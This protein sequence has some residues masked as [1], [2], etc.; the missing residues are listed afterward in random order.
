MGRP[1]AELKL[2]NEEREELRRFARRRTIGSAMAMRSKIVLRCASG[3]DNVDVAEELGLSQSMVSKWRRRFI[4][5]GLEG[6]LDEP[7]VGR[8]RPVT[9]AD[10]ERVV[11]KT[12]HDS[13]RK[14]TH[15]STRSLAKELGMTQSAV[16]RIWK[17]FGLRPD[18]SE[19]FSLSKDPQFVEK[20]RDI[21]GLYMAPPENA[22]VLCVDEKSQMQALDRTQP[23]LP[24][25]PAHPER[26]T[27][28]YTRYGT[29]SLFAA[30]DIATG[31]VIGKT[32][33]RHR[34]AE[35]RKFLDDI[36]QAVPEDLDVHLVMDSYGTHKTEMIKRWLLRHP[37]YHVHFTPT[38]SSWLNL[39]ESFFSIVERSVTRRG[40]HKS[41]RALEKDLRAFLDAHNKEPVPYKWTKT[42]DQILAS[43]SRHCERAGLVREERTKRTVHR[44]RAAKVK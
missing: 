27:N 40:V 32:F 41:T 34:S 9:D 35:F 37:R 4:E 13:P 22:L 5:R 36:D 19:S 7:R 33:R 26:R 3:A 29:T 12:L 28:T 1:K 25:I 23:L 31:R 44:I 38:T 30:L 14:G 10:V 16:G 11:D 21:V 42:A 43:L 18:R 39:V 17:A 15:W 6:L 24:M 8:P 2:S 20:V